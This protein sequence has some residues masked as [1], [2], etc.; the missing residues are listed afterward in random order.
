MDQYTIGIIAE[1]KIVFSKLINIEGLN[2]VI[3]TIAK[4]IFID[5]KDYQNRLKALVVGHCGIINNISYYFDQEIIYHQEKS[6]GRYFFN[7]TAYDQDYKKVLNEIELQYK[8]DREKFLND[9]QEE[10]KI[11]VPA[12]LMN[13]LFKVIDYA[14]DE[15]YDRIT[16]KLAV[17]AN[18]TEFEF[19]DMT[20]S[21]LDTFKD[22]LEEVRNSVKKEVKKEID[23]IYQNY[24][25]SLIF[26][27]KA[28][29]DKRYDTLIATLQSQYNATYAK[30]SNLSIFAEDNTYEINQ[31][32]RDALV[33]EI[34]KVFERLL[35]ESKFVY[36][37]LS[38]EKSLN[39][40]Q[41]DELKNF[42]LLF[43]VGSEMGD[44]TILLE[45]FIEKAEMRLTQEKLLFRNNILVFFVNLI[46]LLILSYLIQEKII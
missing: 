21:L 20:Y 5:P 14:I 26:E 39:S 45:D 28:N 7:A 1:I 17:I 33:P 2:Q 34:K 9:T 4:N 38:I 15:A 10:T 43:D 35:E 40:L 23:R 8:E 12:H 29:I 30:Y 41:E 22:A 13:E 42:T 16:E 36:N 27:I 11:Y 44:I 19:L 25:D 37:Q 32:D 3:E 46:K 18:I 24:M 31:L 6:K